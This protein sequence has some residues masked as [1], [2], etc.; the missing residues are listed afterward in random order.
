MPFSLGFWA[1]AGAGGA[2]GGAMELIST[3]ILSSTASSVTFSSIPSTYKHLQIRATM[4]ANR[5]GAE[6]EIFALRINGDTAANYSAHVLL[7]NGGSVSST[8]YTGESY[9]RGEAF[10]AND[11]ITN[12][13]GATVI[14]VLDY[15]NATTYKQTR[16]ASGRCGS[17]QFAISV[18]SGSWRSTSV[19]SSVTLLTYFGSSFVA[20]SRFSLYGI[21]G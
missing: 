19:V 4:R 11:D 20:G 5:S 1:A 17:T 15:A 21:K 8:S 10:A 14:D 7:G 3:T 6:S 9:I 12:A 16:F 13:F 2:G 18:R